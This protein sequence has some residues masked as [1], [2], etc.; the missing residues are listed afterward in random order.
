MIRVVGDAVVN[1]LWI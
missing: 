1:C